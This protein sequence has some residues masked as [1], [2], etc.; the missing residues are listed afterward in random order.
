M[1]RPTWPPGATRNKFNRSTLSNET[2]KRTNEWVKLF[3]QNEEEI[4]YI[5]ETISE[6]VNNASFTIPL[7][8]WSN[9]SWRS[10]C[11]PK[12]R[13]WKEFHGRSLA[14]RGCYGKLF[15][16]RCPCRRQWLGHVSSLF[17][18][19]AFCLFQPVYVSM[20]K[21]WEY[22][23]KRRL[24]AEQ[25]QR[26]WFSS[27]LGFCPTKPT[28]LPEQFRCCDLAETKTKTSRC[29]SQWNVHLELRPRMEHLKQR[30]RWL[31]R[32]GVVSS[33]FFDAIFAKLSMVRTYDHHGTC[34][35]KHLDPIDEY[36]HHEH[37]EYAPRHGQYPRIQPMFVHLKRHERKIRR[38][39][40]TDRHWP[41]LSLTACAWRLLRL[42]WSWTKFTISVR[43][44][45]RKT[46]GKTMD[47]PVDW[48][49]SS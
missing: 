34:C 45:A 8:F 46:A 48:P 4:I 1:K 12:I 23:S 32:N 7:S 9:I 14:Y 27:N 29:D 20:R 44:G 10:R 15:S 16:L 40:S 35:R 42:I 11:P 28:E 39:S 30:W 13:G 21:P 33:W 5:E 47:F 36:H 24:F 31:K 49:F 17:V 43:M 2:P 38:S 37:V 6:D 18:D 25:R 19:Y 3:V 26:L 22:R 41:A